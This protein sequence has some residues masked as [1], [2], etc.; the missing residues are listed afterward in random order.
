MVL[1]SVE[2]P[3]SLPAPWLDVW[4]GALKAMKDHG[5]WAPAMRPLLDEYVFA[6]RAASDVREGFGW[7]DHLEESV[8]S[9]EIDWLVLRQI[10]TGLPMVWDRHAKRASA[11]ADQLGL[12]PKGRKAGGLGG[13]ADKDKPELKRDSFEALDELAP[14]RSQTA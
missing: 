14:R 8:A 1:P 9:E 6:L 12:T 4:R 3:P 7:L 11:L 2:R 10:A 13:K 5:T